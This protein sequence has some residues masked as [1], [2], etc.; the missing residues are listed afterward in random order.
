MSPSELKPEDRLEKMA[1]ILKAIAHHDRL[2]IVN[3]LLNGVCC[4]VELENI[5]G[6]TQSH[7]SQQLIKLKLAG[8]VKS[9]RDGQKVYYSLANDSIKRIVKSIL[10]EI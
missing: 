7:T 5:L 4:T 9:R 6:K 10:G 8:I 3:I 2:Q 1:Q